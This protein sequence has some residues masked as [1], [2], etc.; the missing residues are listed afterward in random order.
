M[1]HS[2]LLM[3][4]ALPLSFSSYAQSRVIKCE[5]EKGNTIYHNGTDSK[6]GLKCNSTNLA[7]VDKLTSAPRKISG[8]NSSKSTSNV[9]SGS[10]SVSSIDQEFRDLKRRDILMSEL[11]QEKKQSFLVQ[12]MLN[13]ANKN[14]AIQVNQLNN[15]L[16]SH[17]LNINTLEKELKMPTTDFNNIVSSAI[18]GLGIPK[19]KENST[20]PDFQ[21][22]GATIIKPPTNSPDNSLV[23]S[24][25]DNDINN[26]I[27]KENK[28]TNKSIGI[29]DL[30]SMRNDLE[31][32]RQNREG[33]DEDKSQH[34]QTHRRGVNVSKANLN[35][36][37]LPTALSVPDLGLGK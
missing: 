17:Q 23:K 7:T 30:N 26:V 32:L 33:S 22:E 20:R 5:D 29:P 24:K 16:K 4:I 34:I 36:E 9:N 6:K 18:P 3:F 14:D 12:D 2:L 27:K 13:K 10:G 25:K 15:M 35:Y 31:R 28:A 21:I 37:P 11:E 19:N 1:K 8:N